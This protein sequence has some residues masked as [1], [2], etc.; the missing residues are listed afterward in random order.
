MSDYVSIELYTWPTKTIKA[1]LLATYHFPGGSVE[2]AVDKDIR[3]ISMSGV[4]KVIDLLR[5]DDSFRIFGTWLD[6]DQTMQYDGYRSIDRQEI[7]YE[8]CTITELYGKIIWDD[9]TYEETLYVIPHTLDV[10]QDTGNVGQFTYNLLFAVLAK[11]P[12]AS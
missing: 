4:T 10:D 9:G 11:E 8:L 12:K 7:L 3:T 5:T 2:R 1:T 6:D